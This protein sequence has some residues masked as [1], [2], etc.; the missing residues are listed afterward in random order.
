MNDTVIITTDLGTFKAFRLHHT[1]R[2]TP[3][4]EII[5]EIELLDAHGKLGDKVTDQAGRW[6]VPMQNMAM[7]YG[8]RQKIELELRRRLVKQLAER[9]HNIVADRSVATC[10]FAASPEI[11]EQILDEA[12]PQVRGKIE[13]N[14]CC[15]LTNSDKN[16]LLRHFLQPE[17]SGAR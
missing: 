4:L 16:E 15:N 6:K 7:S 17:F 3:R 8:E 11:N 14:L 12:G 1:E 2:N 13:K 9:I 5:E 10:Y